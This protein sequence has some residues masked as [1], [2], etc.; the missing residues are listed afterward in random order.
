MISTA[1]E[2]TRTSSDDNEPEE[3]TRPRTARWKAFASWRW[4]TTRSRS[5]APEFNEHGDEILTE[6]LGFDRDAVIDLKVN[7]MVG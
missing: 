2:P 4:R 7:G 3:M 1:T 6:Q 5:R